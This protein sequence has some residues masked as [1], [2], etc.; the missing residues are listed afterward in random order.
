M[1]S[2]FETTWRLVDDTRNRTRGR[3]HDL[4]DR[5]LGLL[6]RYGPGLAAVS[7]VLLISAWAQASNMYGAP[8]RRDDEGTYVAQAWAVM[9]WHVLAHYTFW[10]DHPPLG[11]IIMAGWFAVTGGLHSAPSAVDA[12][13]QFMFF[14]QELNA[15]LLYLLARRVGMA[16]WTSALAVVA[17]SV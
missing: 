14:V 13:R 15:A 6:D 1:T 5:C 3:W 16:R 4:T 9:H 8:Q 17:F 2:A 11:W 10:Y 12:G 7:A